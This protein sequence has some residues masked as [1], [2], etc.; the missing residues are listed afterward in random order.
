MAFL[1]LLLYFNLFSKKI[2]KIEQW[3][4]TVAYSCLQHLRKTSGHVKSSLNWKFIHFHGGITVCTFA[5]IHYG[6]S[7]VRSTWWRS[8]APWHNC[9]GEQHDWKWCHQS[10]VS[11]YCGT[12]LPCQSSNPHEHLKAVHNHSCSFWIFLPDCS[13]V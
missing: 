12:S 5:L 10:P 3:Q 4:I 11:W 1:V 13:P 6:M 9:S 8:C 7:G 2:T